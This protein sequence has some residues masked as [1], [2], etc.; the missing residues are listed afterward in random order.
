MF[1]FPLILI[2]EILINEV[3]ANPKGKTGGGAPEDRNEFVEIYN[4]T[5]DTFNLLSWRISDF[6]ARDT[7]IPWRDSLILIK[8]PTLKINTTLLPPKTYA[9]I[10]DLEYTQT[11]NGEYVMPYRFPEGLIVLTVGNTTIGDG[12]EMNDS[13]ILY[14]PDSSIVSTFS[15]PRATKDGFSIERV[16]PEAPDSTENWVECLD[17][18]GSTP[19]FVN[20]TLTYC[21]PKIHSLSVTKQEK[22]EI[23][24][25]LENPSYTD[26]GRWRLV[27]KIDG[28]EIKR[29]EGEGLRPKSETTFAFTWESLAFGRR[30]I[31]ARLFAERDCDTTNNLLIT[32]F[33]NLLPDAILLTPEVFS[34]DGDGRDDYLE[35]ALSL[36]EGSDLAIDIF[37]L[38]GKKVKTIHKGKYEKGKRLLW[39]GEDDN[40]QRLSRGIYIVAVEYKKGRERK[41]VKRSCLLAGKR[42]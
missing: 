17:T 40:G 18:A 24:V 5:S 14:S 30:E 9:L 13:L 11:G 12:L 1:F 37:D 36:E 6:D 20:S 41:L 32:Y 31:T 26:C 38:K 22:I 25:K 15:F 28:K 10:L 39:S 19:G 4:N 2:Q 8:Y 35:I 27:F 7:I 29:I 34:P 21:D 23:G 16:K 3:M 42:R 33:I